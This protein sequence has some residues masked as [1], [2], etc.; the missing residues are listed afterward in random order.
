MNWMVKFQKNSTQL[1]YMVELE[2]SINENFCA[3][4]LKLLFYNHL[5]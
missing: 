5:S 2:L 4:C 1:V 3:L